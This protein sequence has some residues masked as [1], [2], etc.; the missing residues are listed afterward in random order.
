LF[1]PQVPV[2]WGWNRDDFLKAICQKAGLPEDAWKEGADLY[3]FTAQ[4]FREDE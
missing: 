1:L 3:I 2:E 4:V